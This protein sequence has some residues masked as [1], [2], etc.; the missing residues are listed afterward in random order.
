MNNYI[1]LFYVTIYLLIGI[2]LYNG[3]LLLNNAIIGIF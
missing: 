2:F 1:I 3:I